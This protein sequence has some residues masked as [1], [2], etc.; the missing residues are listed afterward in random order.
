MCGNELFSQIIIYF[1]KAEVPLLF[2]GLFEIITHLQK[3]SIIAPNLKK[4]FWRR[5][6]S[7]HPGN[8]VRGSNL[9][10]GLPVR[11]NYEEDRRDRLNRWRHFDLSLK[12][13]KKTEE[14]D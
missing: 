4:K 6:R 5:N 12:I 8:A 11:K 10:S 3:T 1:V 7:L 14:T 2:K 13:M 9:E